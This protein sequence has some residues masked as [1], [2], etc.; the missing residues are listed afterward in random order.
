VK[1]EMIF[2]THNSWYYCQ[3]GEDEIY[4]ISIL[5]VKVVDNLSCCTIYLF[6]K[7]TQTEGT[8]SKWWYKQGSR[9]QMPQW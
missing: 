2:F 1:N 3:I 5:I 8:C 6:Y 9:Q 7:C 4:N